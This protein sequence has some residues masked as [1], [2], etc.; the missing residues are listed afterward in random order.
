MRDL[1]E[2]EDYAAIRQMLEERIA[3][4]LRTRRLRTTMSNEAIAARTGTA[5]QLGYLFGVW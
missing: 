3:G 1:G 2:H 4:W 5:K